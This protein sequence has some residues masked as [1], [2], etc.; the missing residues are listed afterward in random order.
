MDSVPTCG[1]KELIKI[2]ISNVIGFG[3]RH[4]EVTRLASFDFK[5]NILSM[6]GVLILISSLPLQMG[7]ESAGIE[8]L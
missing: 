6:L 4:A 7:T 8:S 2:E 1:T 3:Y 5:L